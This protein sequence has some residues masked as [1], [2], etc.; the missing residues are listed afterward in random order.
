MSDT[1]SFTDHIET[2][3][4]K[5][6][7][8]CGWIIRTFHARDMHTMK[9]LWCSIVQPHIDYCSQLWT[10][11]RVGDIQ[12]IESLFR[13]F[14]SK[15]YPISELNYWGRLSALKIYSQER[16]MERYWIIY[17]WK[18]LEGIA[19]NV[20]IKSY[21]STRQGRLCQVP[22][23]KQCTSGKIRAIREGSLQIRGPQL[24]NT[25]PVNIQIG[26]SVTSFK[27]KLDKYLQNIPDKPKCQDTQSKPT[28]T[29]LH[30]WGVPEKAE[31]NSWDRVTNL[32]REIILLN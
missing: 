20:G 3:C 5:V 17:T 18:I 16:R 15:I 31:H 12:K 24:F 29:P 7:Q 28:Q 30:L 1:L 19:P 9:T 22:Q 2:V 13:S 8:K 32:A 14:S 11:H 21:T 26:C 27:H 25:L 4:N 23:I 10:P 6:T